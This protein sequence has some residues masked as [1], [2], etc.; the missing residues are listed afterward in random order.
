[1]DFKKSS[2][3]REREHRDDEAVEQPAEAREDARRA[4]ARRRGDELRH[5]DEGDGADAE[6]E[7]EVA[8]DHREERR[9]APRVQ[10][11]GAGG[12]RPPVVDEKVQEYVKGKLAPTRAKPI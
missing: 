5:H 4:A 6:V 12:R 7:R 3:A 11:A 2:A 9:P 1:M 10:P 8:P